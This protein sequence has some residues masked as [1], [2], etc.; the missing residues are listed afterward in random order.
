MGCVMSKGVRCVNEERGK[1]P[2]SL[3]WRFH[4]SHTGGGGVSTKM[5]GL[6]LSIIERKKERMNAT[7]SNAKLALELAGAI[8]RP[9]SN[10]SSNH[11][12][13]VVGYTSTATH[14]Q[15]S[16]PVSNHPTIKTWIIAWTLS[17]NARGGVDL[18][19]SG[20]SPAE[21][22]GVGGGERPRKRIWPAPSV[23]RAG[24]PTQP[25][26]DARCSACAFDRIGAARG[27][28]GRTP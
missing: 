16:N 2:A 1:A 15:T 20:K 9:R 6:R 8:V 5:N 11:G 22:M 10:V 24:R 14:V 7:H 23:F 3:A 4:K 27:Q 13:R 25:R 28:S 17:I 19:R 18:G 26:R 12:A 21:R